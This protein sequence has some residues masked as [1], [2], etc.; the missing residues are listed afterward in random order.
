MGERF[1]CV[2]VTI[3]AASS[4]FVSL[5]LCLSACSEPLESADWTIPVPEGTRIIEY[6][7]VPL[8][9]R[10]AQIEL[11]EDLLIGERGDDLNY[12]FGQNPPKVA[13]DTEGRIYAADSFLDR[14]QVFSPEGEYLRTIGR[15]GRGPGEFDRP[16]FITVAGQTVV[17]SQQWMHGIIAWTLAG[18]YLYDLNISDTPRRTSGTGLADGTFVGRYPIPSMQGVTVVVVRREATGSEIHRYVE[19]S[20]Q[21]QTAY[22]AHPSGAVYVSTI[23]NGRQQIT[24]FAV[25]GEIRWAIRTP[26]TELAPV[27]LKMGV[28]GDL[29]VFSSCARDL[30]DLTR[31]VDVYSPEGKLRVAAWMVDVDLDI[32]WQM[33][34]EEHVYG[35]DVDPVIGEWRVVRYRLI[36]PFE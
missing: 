17:V 20:G 30:G 32:G 36:E 6:A 26:R 19:L 23:Q 2:R 8:K 31:C 11:V 12:I 15:R 25:T 1:S 34:D 22:A 24:A 28:G 35:A 21:V 33:A 14:I 13:V 27:T 18:D 10:T 16:A 4:V 7:T 29:Y 3:P 9:E 5:A